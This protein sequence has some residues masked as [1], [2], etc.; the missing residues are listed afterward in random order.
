MAT[1]LSH[2]FSNMATTYNSS[3]KPEVQHTL[4][5]QNDSPAKSV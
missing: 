3:S 4:Q 5:N 1:D 2:D